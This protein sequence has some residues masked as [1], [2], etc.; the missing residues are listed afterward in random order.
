MNY[1][2]YEN[3]KG[4]LNELKNRNEVIFN[5]A[6]TQVITDGMDKCKDYDID[7]IK[8]E[9]DKAEAKEHQMVSIDFQL[10][11]YKTAKQISE[12][13]TPL[14]VFMFY[15]EFVS[16]LGI[17]E[18]NTYKKYLQ[19][20][21]ALWREENITNYCNDEEWKNHVCEELYIDEEDLEDIY[22]NC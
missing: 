20:I 13:C 14:S 21:I 10:E 19:N 9:L 4:F 5:C 11:I 7:S 3:V 12:K 2:E 8:E 6:L 16:A 18:V 1:K 17:T 22:K 15:K